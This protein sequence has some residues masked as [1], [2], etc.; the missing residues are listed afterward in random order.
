MVLPASY[1][2][3]LG[4][5]SLEDMDVIIHPQSQQPRPS[6]LSAGEVEIVD[7]VIKIN[8]VKS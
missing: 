6:F 5:I 1:E 3:L 4:A 2:P 7:T 8:L